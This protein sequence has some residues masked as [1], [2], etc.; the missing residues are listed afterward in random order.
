LLKKS[1]KKYSISF[2]LCFLI[3][4]YSYSLD[5]IFAV[6]FKENFQEK[7]SEEIFNQENQKNNKIQKLN[8]Y[9]IVEKII[10]N[11]KIC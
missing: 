1:F 10:K 2:S 9:E 5:N 4:F 7:K 11:S 8:I 3:I 6:S